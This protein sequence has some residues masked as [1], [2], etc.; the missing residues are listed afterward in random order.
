VTGPRIKAA[1]DRSALRLLPAGK[2]LNGSGTKQGGVK[3]MAAAQAR[4]M[5]VFAAFEEAALMKVILPGIDR[6]ATA[7][8]VTPSQVRD[9][10]TRLV[11][12]GLMIKNTV[13]IDGRVRDDFEIRQ[14]AAAGL[15]VYRWANSHVQAP[16]E[17]MTKIAAPLPP[18]FAAISAHT[19]RRLGEFRI[20]GALW[21]RVV[22]TAVIH[23]LRPWQMV[24]RALQVGLDAID[25]GGGSGGESCGGS[26]R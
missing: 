18:V 21:E 15:T 23:G 17:Q 14:G 9:Y 5:R 16:P 13:K 11:R 19:G 8:G 25:A 22:D 26:G 10:I 1:V 7:L 2:T 3:V 24:V 6:M 12:D 4:R 20:D